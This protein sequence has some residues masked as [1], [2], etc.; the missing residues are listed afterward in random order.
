MATFFA[1]VADLK[2]NLQPTSQGGEIWFNDYAANLAFKLA[3]AA[4]VEAS[5][6]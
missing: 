5:C 4:N 6:G 1:Q 2:I 3:V